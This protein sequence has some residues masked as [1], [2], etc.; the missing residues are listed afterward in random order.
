LAYAAHN[1]H[2]LSE[3]HYLFASEIEDADEAAKEVGL[4]FV[5]VILTE[6]VVLG[7]LLGAAVD[8]ENCRDA[9]AQEVG[10]YYKPSLRDPNRYGLQV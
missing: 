1:Q 5:V 6:F 10:D 2:F 9:T 7:Y 8:L 4:A 3:E